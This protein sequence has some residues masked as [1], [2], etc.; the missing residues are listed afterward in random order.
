MMVLY[1]FQL[2]LSKGMQCSC[3]LRRLNLCPDEKAQASQPITILSATFCTTA[4]WPI[5]NLLRVF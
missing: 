4:N 2:R 3:Q 1:C 5:F